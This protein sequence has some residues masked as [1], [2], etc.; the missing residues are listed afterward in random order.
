MNILNYWK[1]KKIEHLLP[2]YIDKSL[3]ENKMRFIEV[4][5]SSCSDCSQKLAQFQKIDS[6]FKVIEPRKLPP[7]YLYELHYKLVKAN[8]KT[9]QSF[10]AKLKLFGVIPRFKYAFASFSFIFLVLIS[11]HF[12]TKNSEKNILLDATAFN[13]INLN[14]DGVIRFRIN[15]D[16]GMENVTLKIELPSGIRTIKNGQVNMEQGEIVWHGDLDKGENEITISVKG[17]RQGNW[18]AKAVFS[19]RSSIR[20]I[21]IPFTIL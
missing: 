10:I 21:K 8:Q 2:L 18:E 15:T 9:N 6:T 14:Q 13:V 1:C 16:R 17:V 3:P 20:K 5:L 4:H 7:G 11:V 12:I 19:E